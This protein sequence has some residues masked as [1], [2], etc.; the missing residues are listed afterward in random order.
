MS[1][2]LPEHHVSRH[3]SPAK[4]NPDTGVI[5]GTAFLLRENEPFLSVNWLEYYSNCKNQLDQLKQ[6]HEFLSKKFQNGGIRPTH[7]YIILNK[8]IT[9]DYIDQKFKKK[10]ILR[11]E[12]DKR[13]T[14]F[15]CH[16]GIFDTAIDKAR[17]RAVANQLAILVNSNPANKIM[18]KDLLADKDKSS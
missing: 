18:V 7:A 8:K 3:C 2:I 15:N 12:Q 6:I 14:P 16:S 10:V 11:I 5:E 4:M 1:E 17:E 9:L 13:T